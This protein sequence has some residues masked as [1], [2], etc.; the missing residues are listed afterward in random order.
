[1]PEIIMGRGENKQILL[2][3]RSS[4]IFKEPLLHRPH[5]NSPAK[6][7]YPNENHLRD[8]RSQHW[9]QPKSQ[10]GSGPHNQGCMFCWQIRVYSLWGFPAKNIYILVVTIASWVGGRSESQPQKSQVFQQTRPS[11][12][13]R[14]RRFSSRW[15]TRCFLQNGQSLK[16]APADLR[17]ATLALERKKPLPVI[18]G[19]R[20]PIDG[21]TNWFSTGFLHPY[22]CTLYE[23]W[24]S[25]WT[26]WK[27]RSTEQK[28]LWFREELSV[29]CM[30]TSLF[31]QSPNCPSQIGPYG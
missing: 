29:F 6:K 10:L 20:A 23:W 13:E 19:V 31:C 9:G 28:S 18:N 2:E 15:E 1:M 11:A 12:R 17:L 25:K 7:K 3:I 8:L 21:L 4:V 27:K 26:L 30:F 14:K 16:C 5:Q 24:H 22:K